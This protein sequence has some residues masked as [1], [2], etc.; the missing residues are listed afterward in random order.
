MYGTQVLASSKLMKDND[1]YFLGYP[2][3]RLKVGNLY[4]YIIGLSNDL[5]KAREEYNKIRQK[6]R[7]SFLVVVKDESANRL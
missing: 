6:Y 7:D 2:V 3:K 4:K 5:S 1:P